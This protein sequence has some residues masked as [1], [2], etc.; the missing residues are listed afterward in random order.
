MMIIRFVIKFFFVY[1]FYVVFCL[2]VQIDVWLKTKPRFDSE[3]GQL[4]AMIIAH[5]SLCCFS[6]LFFEG[7]YD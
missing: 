4:W 1:L 5:L 2:S 7:L 3:F 6:L